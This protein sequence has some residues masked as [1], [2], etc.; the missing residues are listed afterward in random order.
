MKHTRENSVTNAFTSTEV[1][2]VT[3]AGRGARET[4]KIIFPRCLPPS[5][6]AK[7]GKPLENYRAA[8]KSRPQID[9]RRFVP[10]WF[11]SSKFIG[12][13]PIRSERRSPKIERNA[14]SVIRAHLGG[15]VGQFYRKRVSRMEEALARVTGEPRPLRRRAPAISVGSEGEGRKG[16][17]RGRKVTTSREESQRARG[18]AKK[19]NRKERRRSIKK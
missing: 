5:G 15:F 1:P 2:R 16:N 14:K 7:A 17:K 8:V 11:D 10:A 4:L 13:A 12:A 19:S 9:G 3:A 18:G 6:L